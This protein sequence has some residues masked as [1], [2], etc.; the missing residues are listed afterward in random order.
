MKKLILL[1]VLLVSLLGSA[2]AQFRI[3]LK[4]SYGSQDVDE[5][6][7]NV[8]SE[9]NNHNADFI[10]HCN[11]GLGFRI[12]LGNHLYINPEANVAINSVWDSVDN[13]NI[14]T[15]ISQA[16][17]NSQE[18]MLSI[19]VM[20]GWKILDLDG[21]AAARIYVGPEFYTT[22]GTLNDNGEGSKKLNFSN[23]DFRTYSAVGGIGVDLLGFI[24]IDARATYMLN[25]EAENKLFYTLG[26]GLLL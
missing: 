23:F 3:N 20:V 10:R 1:S 8:Q 2:Q 21:I 9:V 26:V 15:S 17:A 6:I 14:F 13:G 25:S 18:A 12:G 24:S 11:F 16:F 19:P 4:L 22:F 7:N 5:I